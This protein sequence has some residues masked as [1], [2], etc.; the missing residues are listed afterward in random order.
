[1]QPDT[2]VSRASGASRRMGA[3][4]YL[5]T[6][7]AA[8]VL[9]V[10]LVAG[11]VL[12]TLLDAHRAA[13]I[14]G[15][16]KSARAISL[17]MDQELASAETVLRVLATSVYLSRGDLAGFRQQAIAALTGDREGIALY[18][19]QGRQLVDTRVAAGAADEPQTDARR[20]RELVASSRVQVSRLNRSRDGK[21]LTVTV[22][23]PVVIA[24]ER[25]LLSQMYTAAHF[26]RV[27]AQHKVPASW[28]VGVFDTDHV[29]IARSHRSGD[30]V[31]RPGADLLRKAATNVAEGQVRHHSREGIEVYDIF[32]RAP[33][34]GWLVSIGVPAQALDALAERAVG[35]AVLGT[36]A[37]L[38]AAA[39]IAL[40]VGHR[41]NSSLGDIARAAAA[42][43][44][45]EALP[46]HRPSLREINALRVSL[47]E[48]H[49][50]LARETQAH[51]RAETERR[52]LF[53]SEQ[54]ARQLAEQ[55]NRTKD[56]FLAM[57]GHELRNP[58]SAISGAVA[59]MKAPNARNEHRVHAREVISRQVQH[60]GRVVD[61]LL[62]LS[63]VMT[64]KIMLD[65]KPVDLAQVAANCLAVMRAAGRVGE[66]DLKVTLQPAWVSGDAV[67][68]E[69]VVGNLLS[70][71]FKYT[72][73]EGRVELEVAAQRD[74]AIVRVSD[75]GLGIPKH[76]LAHVF[77]VFVQ[78]DQS[79]ERA[80]GGLGIGLALVQRLVH[81]HAGEVG[82]ESAGDGLGSTFTVRLPRVAP[83]DADQGAT[84]AGPPLR[85]RLHVLVVDDHEDSRTMLRLLLEQSGH[86][87]VEAVD[88]IDGVQLALSYRPD[89]AIIDIGLPGING[90]EVARRLRNLPT[91]RK[92]GL[93]ALT[94]YGQ[95]EDRRRA[96]Q[97]GFDRH[98]VKPVDAEQLGQALLEVSTN[99]GRPAV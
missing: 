16:L 69:Q 66:H 1:M 14:R 51:A 33:R 64:G 9:P 75:T 88:G 93:I 35:T 65:L 86:E 2:T 62:D 81:L 50:M 84:A 98:L 92:I 34:S 38:V 44:R 63:R 74:D 79:L 43:G 87:A 61:D 60:L 48:T 70:N 6:M 11:F 10:L 4:A 53:E 56:E 5:A 36:L 52:Q 45:G 46:P 85:R 19:A 12:N 97:S 47:E 82:A 21:S 8:A 77:D 57:L 30:F 27:L 68:L 13:A 41:L 40:V 29:M 99:P 91:S 96:L 58:L 55:Q 71:A 26:Q 89:V 49:A 3:R 76:L 90:Y 25:F 15:V 94:G 23:V 73:P 7:A 20:L 32:A 17:A 95:D 18:D 80:K 28:I 24:G 42:L 54:A 67:R 39:A 59:L 83:P 22:D 72:P 31:G 37:A 78:G